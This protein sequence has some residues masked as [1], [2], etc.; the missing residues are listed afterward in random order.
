MYYTLIS[1]SLQIALGDRNAFMSQQPGKCI[2][3]NAI[4]QVEMR[5][6]MAACMRGYANVF[7]DTNS[8]SI[9]SGTNMALGSLY[10]MNHNDA[11]RRSEQ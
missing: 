3:V 8:L 9:R 5:K 7:T 10:V 2:Q 1:D 11:E 4:L 6:S